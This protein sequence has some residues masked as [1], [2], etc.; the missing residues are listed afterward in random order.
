MWRLR[1]KSRRLN[2]GERRGKYALGRSSHRTVGVV[3]LGW[4]SRR[5]GGCLRR[6]SRVWLTAWVCEPDNYLASLVPQLTC[7]RWI[8]APTM[9]NPSPKSGTAFEESRGNI[10][11]KRRSDKQRHFRTRTR[12][13][14]AVLSALVRGLAETSGL[15]GC[16]G[17]PAGLHSRQ[18]DSKH[19]NDTQRIVKRLL[20]AE[21]LIEL[22]A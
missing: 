21:C 6:A 4:R 17:M 1:R 19:L 20:S 15:T 8:A 22:Q 16:V 5:S 14:Q 13:G 3:L 9:K 12:H 10:S 7:R 11:A 18:R 2:G